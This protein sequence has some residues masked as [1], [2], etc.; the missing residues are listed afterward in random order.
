M[1]LNFHGFWR[2]L[3]ERTSLFRCSVSSRV[4]TGKPTPTSTLA[5]N[6][7]NG[8]RDEWAKAHFLLL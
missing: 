7:G 2:I 8:G 6:P 4:R 5:G 3:E 1:E